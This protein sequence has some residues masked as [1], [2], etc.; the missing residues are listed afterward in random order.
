MLDKKPTQKSFWDSQWIE[1]LLD[2]TSFEWNFRALVRPLIKDDDFEWA[3][4]LDRGRKAIPPSLVACALILQ[5]KYRLS[6][7]EMER[8]IRFN[9]A[10]KYAL[11]LSMDDCGFDHTLLCKFRKLL[12][13]NNETKFC[14]DKFRGVL[15]EAGYIKAGETAVIDTTHVIADIA[16]PNTIELLQLGIKSLLEATFELPSGVGRQLAKDLQL[17]VVYKN[18]RIGEDRECLTDLVQAGIRLIRYLE[19]SGEID[20]PAVL[21][22]A[23]QLKRIL[24][25][26]IDGDEATPRKKTGHVLNRLVSTVDPDAK[27]GRKSEEKKFVGYKAQIIESEN[28]F[29]SAVDGMAGN[30]HD[31]FGVSK[32]VTEMENIGIRPGYLVGDKAYGDEP[33]GMNMEAQGVKM[34]TPLRD[35]RNFSNDR[36]EYTDIDGKNARPKIKCP[37]G[38]ETDKGSYRPSHE[39]LFHFTEC[40]NCHLKEQCTTGENRSVVISP[41]YLFR[42]QKN[43]FNKTILYKD[44]MKG[45]S[46]IERKNGELKNLLGF[47]RCRYRGM[48]KFKFQCFFTALVA[49]IKRFITMLANAP[50]MP[51]LVWVKR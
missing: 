15:I 9:L 20:H 37:A 50:P 8:Q 23:E 18:A 44:L 14:F 31:N 42:Q 12:I 41:S 35:E 30:R 3:Y 22:K 47:K 6:D 4:D 28:E 2:K 11:G 24:R 13:E 21:G 33:L 10:T 40:S 25:E 39:R 26:N 7:R 38:R 1:H 34:V 43:L 19:K 17:E 16:I 27:F 51:A 48:A 32:L 49:N 5:Q 36:F 45:R 46:K 29:I